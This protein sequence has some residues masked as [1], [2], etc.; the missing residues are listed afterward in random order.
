MNFTKYDKYGAYHWVWYNNPKKYKRY[1]PH[2]DKIV[3]WVKEKNIIDIG[4]GDGLITYYTNSVGIDNCDKA[5]SLANKRGVNVIL[6]DVYNMPYRDEE[7]S[8]A[9]LIDVLEHFEFPEKA[10]QEIRRIVKKY[11]YIVI[12]HEDPLKEGFHYN[13]W[14][15]K[16]LIKFIKGQGF[17]LCDDIDIKYNKIYAKFKKV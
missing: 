13:R 10:L 1:K 12:P 14:G 8:S 4:A 2:V 17:I 7:F 11:I 5:V 16:E 3:K 6:G 9:M 15:E